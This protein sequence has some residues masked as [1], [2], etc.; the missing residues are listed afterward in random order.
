M[1]EESSQ[2]C[3][4]WLSRNKL[5]SSDPLE[6]VSEKKFLG[7][8]NEGG[9]MY[10]LIQRGE[11]WWIVDIRRKRIVT[12]LSSGRLAQAVLNSLLTIQCPWWTWKS[13]GRD[14]G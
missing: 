5:D 9:V 12:S 6:A 3:Q 8:G 1:L 2:G 13:E 10:K 11:I 4:Q 7:I 14:R